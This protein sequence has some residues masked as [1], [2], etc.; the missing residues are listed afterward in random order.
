MVCVWRDTGWGAQVGCGGG[1][2]PSPRHDHSLVRH[3]SGLV[4][5][6]GNEG[7]R[8]ELQPVNDVHLFDV[9]TD[10]WHRMPTSVAPV[11]RA[12]H[13]AVATAAG[14]VCVFGGDDKD[15]KLSD[16]HVLCL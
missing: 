10:Q 9:R 15:S 4:L 6:G 12:A 7:G 3:A 14:G 5:F 16:A 11:A 2:R 8:K 13:T 1:E